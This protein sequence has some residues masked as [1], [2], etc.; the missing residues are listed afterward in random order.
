MHIRFCIDPH[1]PDLTAFKPEVLSGQISAKKF[2]GST[3]KES[4][5]P[6]FW[7]GKTLSCTWEASLLVE[8]RVN[9]EAVVMYICGD[10]K[11]SKKTK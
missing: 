9:I 3:L 5:Y 1:S 7:L 11:I 2:Q 4:C 8:L 6:T 10:H